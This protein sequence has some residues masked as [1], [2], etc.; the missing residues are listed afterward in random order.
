MFAWRQRAQ[1]EVWRENLNTRNSLFLCREEWLVTMSRD[2]KFLPKRAQIFVC[3]ENYAE[4]CFIEDHRYSLLRGNIPTKREEKPDG[5]PTNITLIN[6]PE[7]LFLIKYKIATPKVY[8]IAFCQ[9]LAMTLNVCKEI[10]SMDRHDKTKAS[11]QPNLSPGKLQANEI[12]FE[13][14]STQRYLKNPYRN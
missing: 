7:K 9:I 8:F 10:T 4:D 13:N 11:L 6:Q 3:S 14:C 5:I 2:E 1:P 12:N